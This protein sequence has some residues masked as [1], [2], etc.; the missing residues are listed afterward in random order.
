MKGAASVKY[1]WI[2]QCLCVVSGEAQMYIQ[3]QQKEPSSDQKALTVHPFEFS[4][5]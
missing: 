4:K 5:H 3:K 1:T 2:I